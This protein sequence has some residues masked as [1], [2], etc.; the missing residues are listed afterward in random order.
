VEQQKNVHLIK[1][2]EHYGDL[3]KAQHFSIHPL[4]NEAFFF[5]ETAPSEMK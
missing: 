5:C 4:T 2:T 1:E 3:I